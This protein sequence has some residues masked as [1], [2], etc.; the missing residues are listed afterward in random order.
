MI[1]YFISVST[2]SSLMAASSSAIRDS[3]VVLPTRAPTTYHPLD[4]DYTPIII[5]IAAGFACFVVFVCCMCVMH[6]WWLKRNKFTEVNSTPLHD[7]EKKRKKEERREMKRQ[8]EGKKFLLGG[9]IIINGRLI[10]GGLITG[11]FFFVSG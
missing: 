6:S 10:A 4:T 1:I 5:S 9:L 3:H 8:A 11:I 2:A 7:I